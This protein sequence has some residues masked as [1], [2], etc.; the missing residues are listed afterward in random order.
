ADLQQLFVRVQRSARRRGPNLR[1]PVDRARAQRELHA[2]GQSEFRPLLRRASPRGWLLHSVSEESAPRWIVP[3]YVRNHV[4]RL[5]AEQPWRR[6][7]H[8]AWLDHDAAELRVIRGGRHHAV[9]GELSG[10]LPGWRRGDRPIAH[11]DDVDRAAGAVPGERGGSDQ[12]TRRQG[13]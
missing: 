13:V 1:W 10:A 4:E 11:R 7:W 12:P 5:A 8:G 2:A 3:D 9:S 6:D